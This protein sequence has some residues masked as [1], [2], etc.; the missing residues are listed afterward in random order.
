MA[1][2]TPSGKNGLSQ[3]L[4]E[5]VGSE[6]V[7]TGEQDTASYRVDG[8]T[9]AAV[10]FATTTEQIAQIVKAG[11]E[12]QA[13]IIPWGGGS[14]QQVGP[15][16]STA[17]VVLCLKNMNKVIELDVS[18]FTAQVE[19]GLTN[20]ELQKQ[21][22]GHKLFF[23]L[24]PPYL[25]TATVGGTLATNASGPL[26]ASYG[27]ARDLVLGITAVTP[28]GDIIHTGG[29]TM[30]NV[31]GID[32]CKLYIGSWGT[33]GIIT[34]AVLRIFPLPE[35]S[36]SFHLT[37]PGIENA[38]P[39]V[40]SLLNSTLWP[41]SVELVDSVAG[42]NLNSAPAEDEVLLLIDND[43]SLESVE[44]HQKEIRALAEANKVRSVITLEDKE[45]I[46]ARHAY[47]KMHQTILGATP[48][49]IQGKASVP[50]SKLGD[51]FKAAREIGR[52]HGVETGLRAHGYNGTLYLYVISANGTD[53]NI[54]GDLQRSAASLGG[55]FVVENAPLAT[56]KNADLWPHRNDYNLMK[57]LKTEFDPN[58]VLNPGRAAGG[59]Y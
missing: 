2:S 19:A 1:K 56:R 46:Q 30:K 58:N 37:F 33:L 29:K 48:S 59:L 55:F 42:R 6:N 53:T 8:L 18:N 38:F 13:S 51:M 24:D 10:I 34:E 49:I 11:N 39:V 16:L 5:I 41:S 45:M 3:K 47:L 23:P 22:G 50:I 26:R 4:A 32:L 15:C 12:F 31:A 52:K 25:E 36:K 43:G 17:E 27:T 7:F 28:A 9:P 40:S 57:R 21:L 14:K 44:R 35:T 54:I 20:Q